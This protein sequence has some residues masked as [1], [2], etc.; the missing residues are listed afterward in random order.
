MR[1]PPRSAPFAFDRSALELENHWLV[2]PTK[3]E[4]TY[5]FWCVYLDVTAGFSAR[6][7]GTF[8]LDES[9]HATA[10]PLKEMLTVRMHGDFQAAP[11]PPAIRND[12]GLEAVPEFLKFYASDVSTPE[13]R[14][15]RGRH[16]NGVGRFKQAPRLLEPLAV[17]DASRQGLSYELGF[18]YNALKQPERAVGVLVRAAAE[19]A[20]NPY[21]A[22][23]LGY[24]YLKLGRNKEA[25]KILLRSVTQVPASNPVQRGQQALHLA[26]AYHAMGEGHQAQEWF[27]KAKEWSPPGSSV[28][29]FF[30]ELDAKAQSRSLGPSRK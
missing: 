5:G 21:V 14:L 11:M 4:G 23:E 16:L 13:Y 2:L 18:A 22:G 6:N 29:R 25:V 26:R 28:G 20:S 7:F 27:G 17:E 12:L 8:V 10:L 15:A 24:A 9:G 3:E 30:R 19:D 1:M